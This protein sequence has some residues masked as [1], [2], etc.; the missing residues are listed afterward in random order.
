MYLAKERN[1]STIDRTGRRQETKRCQKCWGTCMDP[2]PPQRRGEGESSPGGS[3]C[4]PETAMSSSFRLQK[5]IMWARISGKRAVL[6]GNQSIFAETAWKGPVSDPNISL[7]RPPPVNHVRLI[8]NAVEVSRSGVVCQKRLYLRGRMLR[9]ACAVSAACRG[10]A[11]FSAM[12]YIWLRL[13]LQ[14]ERGGS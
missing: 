7:D 13:L 1:H 9:N 2:G 10:T 14:L 4:G 6:P 12:E 3:F 8:K 11:G 5:A